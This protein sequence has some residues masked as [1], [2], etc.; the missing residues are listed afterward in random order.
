M[1]VAYGSEFETLATV[2]LMPTH[3]SACLTQPPHHIVAAAVGEEEEGVAAAELV[4]KHG[5]PV[6]CH[7]Q[8][9]GRP[10]SLHTDDSTDTLVLIVFR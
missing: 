10:Q 8:G 6:A 7:V 9:S 4:V 2:A 1:T 3:L 5:I